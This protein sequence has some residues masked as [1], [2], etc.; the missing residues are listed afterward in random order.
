MPQVI[1]TKTR[2]LL[3]HAFNAWLANLRLHRQVA[4]VF[5]WL[6]PPA[7]PMLIQT[8]RQLVYNAWLVSIP[9]LAHTARARR[10][11]ALLAL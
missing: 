2:T 4:F 5:R 11:L 6:A 1:L 8:Q 7:G 10:S 9:P 3:R